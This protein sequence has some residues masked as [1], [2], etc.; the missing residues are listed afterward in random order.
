MSGTCVHHLVMCREH[1]TAAVPHVCK[2]LHSSATQQTLFT[3]APAAS[4]RCSLCK[5]VRGV[6]HVHFMAATSLTVPSPMNE[7]TA[8]LCFR[9]LY[10]VETVKHQTS[11]CNWSLLLHARISYDLKWIACSLGEH[12]YVQLCHLSFLRLPQSSIFRI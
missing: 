5:S 4:A 6:Q 11:L 10:M 9:H 3:S 12:C 8:T 1:K 2:G 7:L